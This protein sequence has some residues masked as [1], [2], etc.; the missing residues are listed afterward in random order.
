MARVLLL[1]GEC[2]VSSDILYFLKKY[3]D[4]QFLKAPQS[5]C[6]WGK[7]RFPPGEGH[8][9]H[10]GPARGK[11]RWKSSLASKLVC[12]IVTTFTLEL[13]LVYMNY[14]YLVPQKAVALPTTLAGG[15]CT[16]YM[17][18]W[19]ERISRARCDTF[20]VYHFYHYLQSIQLVPSKFNCLH[21]RFYPPW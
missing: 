9:L 20:F 13:W 15:A 19:Y 17:H 21:A 12:R 3:F 16:D 10:Q 2:T 18:I 8:F 1:W 5:D 7:L 6:S 4:K 11:N 14:P